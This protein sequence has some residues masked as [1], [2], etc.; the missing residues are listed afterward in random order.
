MELRTDFPVKDLCE[1]LECA[2]SSVY[3]QS[4][5]TEDRELR[6]AIER[7]ATQWVTYGYRRITKMLQREGWKINHKRV[8]RL[9]S[10]MGLLQTRKR[11]KV[12]TTNSQHTFARYPNRVQ[13][14]DIT[15]PDQVWVADITYVQLGRGHVYLA[16]IMDVFTRAIRGWQLSR[17]LDATSLTI[18]ALK[19]ALKTHCPTIHHSDQGW[20]YACWDYVNLLRDREVQISMASVGE[21]RENG[22]AE[23][24]IRTLKEEEIDLSYYDDFAD[25]KQ[26][27][28]QFIEDVYMTKRIHSSLGYLTPQEFEGRRREQQLVH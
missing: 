4:T 8:R 25:A 6:Q 11:R 20:Q 24:L 18:S 9:M 26:R 27:I 5:Q 21:P 15:T 10:E 23:R 16:V 2:R 22:Y 3:Y 14:L 7:L 28:G 1:V 13:S 17:N 12:R 19:K